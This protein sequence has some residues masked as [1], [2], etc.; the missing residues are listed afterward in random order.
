MDFSSVNV[1]PQQYFGV[2]ISIPISGSTTRQKVNQSKM[3]LQLQ[4]Q[5]LDNT[6]LVKQQ[7]DGLLQLQLQQT[8][9]QL[10]DNKEILSLQQ[11]NDL[12]AENKYNSG[13]MSLDDRL[14]KYDDLLAAQDN[15]LQSLAAFTLA[16]YKVYIRQIDYSSNK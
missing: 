13:I 12:H 7:E 10:A 2:R 8:S 5:Q 3:T 1:L 6:R 14:N 9:D 11:Q 15:Y 4:Q 16:Q